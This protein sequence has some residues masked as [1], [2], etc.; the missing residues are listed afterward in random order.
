MVEGE[1]WAVSGA[2]EQNRTYGLAEC[3]QPDVHLLSSA[4][5]KNCDANERVRR[6]QLEESSWSYLEYWA[7]VI[8][9]IK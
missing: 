5:V 1:L 2:V 9:K 3:E 4:N 8:T 7:M 6:L